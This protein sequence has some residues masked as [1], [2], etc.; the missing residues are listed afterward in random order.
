M[1]QIFLYELVRSFEMALNKEINLKLC[2]SIYM[3]INDYSM[4]NVFKVLAMPSLN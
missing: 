1:K 3:P 4:E 2:Q